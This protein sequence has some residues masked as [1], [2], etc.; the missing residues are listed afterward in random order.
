MGILSSV[1]AAATLPR[2][3]DRMGST[4][5]PIT[6][7]SERD[8]AAVERLQ[9]S[10][11]PGTAPPR[12]GLV[13]RSAGE[14]VGYACVGLN[15]LH[16]RWWKPS[17]VVAVRH[18]RRGIGRR[19]HEALLATVTQRPT[20]EGLQAGCDSADSQAR[21]FLRALGYQKR[22]DCR[23]LTFPLGRAARSREA[24]ALVERAGLRLAS[25][26]APAVDHEAVFRFLVARYI[27][28]HPWSIPVER[29]HPLWEASATD[30]IAQELSF[31]LLAG[32]RVVAAVSAG[33]EGRNLAI[34]W[35]HIEDGW[36]AAE[37]DLL[38]KHLI[39]HQL[40]QAHLHG[41]TSADIELDSTHRSLH[42][43]RGWFPAGAEEVWEIHQRAFD[44]AGGL[45]MT[46]EV[47]M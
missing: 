37:S 13:V 16:P 18:R 29:G 33:R 25:F 38:L 30:G 23:C 9:R 45:A 40:R 42:R 19:L 8:L 31:V 34:V 26:A 1:L 5:H 41:L 14:L 15:P 32:D 7:L 22:L 35:A 47:D 4:V 10:A 20:R 11:A 12:E 36:S 6:P 43:L 46:T 24:A 3:L 27:H 28:E 39:G 21:G 2:G 44:A 17:V